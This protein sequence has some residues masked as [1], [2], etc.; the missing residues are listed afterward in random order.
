MSP[1]MSLLNI[2]NG[3]FGFDIRVLDRRREKSDARKIFCLIAYNY[4]SEG[5]VN[6][7]SVLE[8]HHASVVHN[9]KRAQELLEYDKQFE[10][11]YYNCLVKCKELIPTQERETLKEF[12][13]AKYEA[14]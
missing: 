10:A 6:I 9:R 1:L 8:R 4:L 2:V 13:K 5:I 12:F 14:L 3:H 7:A 11:E